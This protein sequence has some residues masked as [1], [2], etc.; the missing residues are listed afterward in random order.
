MN[1]YHYSLPPK[2]YRDYY[3]ESP[4]SSPTSPYDSDYVYYSPQHQYGPTSSSKHS[5]AC[6]CQYTAP[7]KK[8]STRHS[9]PGHSCSQCYETVPTYAAPAK[10]YV[11]VST[12]KGM[13]SNHRSSSM[14]GSK[15]QIRRSRRQKQ[16]VYV[17]DVDDAYTSPACAD[18]QP[19]CQRSP[20]VCA[21]CFYCCQDQ[22]YDQKPRRSRACRPSTSDGPS[23]KY[24]NTSYAKSAVKATEE[25]ASRAGIPAGYSI[26][27][28]DP[29][30]IPIILLGSVFDANSLGKWV[31]DWTVFH[32][33]ASSPMA[34]VA[35]DL[36]LLLIKLA[37][38]M[39]RAEECVDRIRSIESQELVEDFIASGLRLWEKFE[40]LL[41]NCEQFMW[42]AAK[43]E[44]NSKR[45]SMG[46]HAGTE[47]VASFFGRDRELDNTEK[48]M[49]SIRLWNL[50]FDANCEDIL[51]RPSAA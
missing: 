7:T 8:P 30:E 45:I 41:K 13:R 12:T 39:K 33:G 31:Y 42:R 44:G 27:N 9:S 10:K 43:R 19:T 49:A 25:D 48:I 47:F 29:S 22:I 28:W 40:H 50:R 23:Q 11:Y 15:H 6:S 14:F 17:D 3:H 18:C 34:D 46:K 37:G 51:R 1:P 26:K 5:R 21:D 2:G 20:E 36:W 32:Y 24:S 38:K 4:M 16:P 35:G